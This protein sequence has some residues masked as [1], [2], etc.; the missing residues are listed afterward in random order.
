MENKEPIICG[1]V[2]SDC[3]DVTGSSV[4]A[5]DK[6]KKLF[7][8]LNNL[9]TSETWLPSGGLNT[10]NDGVATETYEECARRELAEEAGIEKVEEIY[11]LGVP[12]ISYYYN[13][14]KKSNRKSLGYNY[15]AVVDSNQSMNMKNEEGENY[16]VDWV[17][18]DNL[19]NSFAQTGD[20]DHWLQALRWAKDK[21]V[22]L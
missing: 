20:V 18:F 11:E 6:S 22:S 14:N 3:K 12:I 13:P 5:Y 7:L 2:L 17:S 21:I 1:K 10:D 19:Y 16:T 4:M 9:N 15:L 8:K